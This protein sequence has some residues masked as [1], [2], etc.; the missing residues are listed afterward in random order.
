MIV[1]KTGGSKKRFSLTKFDDKNHLRNLACKLL[2]H[3]SN[4]NDDGIDRLSVLLS[5]DDKDYALN[6]IGEKQSPIRFVSIF[7]FT[8]NNVILI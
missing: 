1:H 6:D 5:S 7:T 8:Y 2:K 3:R 4:N